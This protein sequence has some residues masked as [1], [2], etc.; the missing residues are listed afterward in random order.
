MR[1]MANAPD[2]DGDADGAQEFDL[3]GDATQVLHEDEHV[4]LK[5]H[6]PAEGRCP[7]AVV[8][9]GRHLGTKSA[10]RL[11]A[12]ANGELVADV[13]RAGV[14][15]HFSYFAGRHPYDEMMVLHVEQVAAGEV[16]AVRL[17]LRV[18]VGGVDERT[19]PFLNGNGR[20]RRGGGHEDLLT[21]LE[22]DQA[23]TANAVDP[24]GAW[25]RTGT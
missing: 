12:G 11:S 6:V 14:Y 8:H 24:A 16:L 15:R 2:S 1:G 23:R 5:L 3:A 13:E 22:P 19:N 18:V 10:P 9:G 7:D 20:G 17:D 21:W 4:A 25:T